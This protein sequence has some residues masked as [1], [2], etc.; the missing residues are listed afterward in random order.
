MSTRQA[1]E[2]RRFQPGVY[3]RLLRK[4]CAEIGIRHIA[5]WQGGMIGPRGAH[6]WKVR[7]Q[8][9]ERVFGQTPERRD[10]AAEYGQG[11]W[12]SG[13]AVEIEH[14][15]ARHRRCVL[16]AII[17]ERSDAGIAPDHIGSGNRLGEVAVGRATEIVDLRLIDRDFARI[18]FEGNIRRA[19]ERV[20]AFVRNQEDHTTIVVLE[21]EG[22]AAG[23]PAFDAHARPEGDNPTIGLVLCSQKNEAIAKYSV[24]SEARQIFAA[25]YVKVLPTERELIR[26]IERERRLIDAKGPGSARRGKK[27]S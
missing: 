7:R 20:V 8:L 9:I 3:S 21:D 18:A 27:K 23:I 1:V 14:V 13:L 6:R 11:G 15:V 19:D 24:L 4:E 26:E 2:M 17:V 10:L 12:L 16:L 22:V 25:K 5:A